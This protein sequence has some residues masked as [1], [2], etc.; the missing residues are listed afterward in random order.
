MASLNRRRASRGLAAVEAAILLPLI[1]L[2]VMAVFEYG[3]MFIKSQQIASAAREGARVGAT[4]N[5]TAQNAHDA[6]KYMLTQMNMTCSY[7]IDIVMNSSP[8]DPVT[9]KI[10]LPY[11]G[12]CALTQFPLLPLPP[13]L[14]RSHTFA[15]EGPL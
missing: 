6:V 11:D 7:T 5:A 8:G 9:V 15:K 12:A 13:T 14:V 10:T 2:L 1:L 4:Q 3:W